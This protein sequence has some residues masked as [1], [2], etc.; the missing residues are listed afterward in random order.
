MQRHPMFQVI[1]GICA[2]LLAMGIGRFAYTPI[3]PLMQRQLQF[4]DAVAG[5]LASS[6]Y[7]GYL[8]GALLAGAVPR[9]AP[10]TPYLRISLAASVLST[11]FMGIAASYAS[12]FVLRFV[13]G[14][15]SAFV[16]VLA[17]S[18]VLDVLASK[19]KTAW[20]GYLYGGVGL[21]IFISGLLVPLFGETWGWGWRG[22]WIG[23]AAFSV[24]CAVFAWRWVCEEAS[25][26]VPAAACVPGK[27]TVP[28]SRWL[29]W[30]IAAYGLEG[31]GYIVTGTFL[32]SIAAN[33]PGMANHSALVWALVGLAAAPSCIVW[34]V[35]ARKR[36]YVRS[37]VAAM[38]LQSASIALPV[39]WPSP[40]GSAISAIMFGATFMGITTLATTLAR[41]MNPAQSSRTIGIATAVYGVGQMLGPIGAGLLV[42]VHQ[43]YSFALVGAAGIVL[44]GAFLT[45]TGF[46]Y[47]RNRKSNAIE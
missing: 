5:Y 43:N 41:L 35:L 4:S 1:G 17:S 15:V 12:W 26:G 9:K 34:S 45:A 20:S 36:G 18:I 23:L 25:P 21:G 31:L 14:V 7:A 46:S 28:S 2:L 33:I 6:N 38:A 16:F 42:S 39:L 37:L 24:L 10:K 8:L 40:A 27:W 19:G 13:S 32:V 29:P 22:A 11:A 44:A 3:L 30:L 47:E